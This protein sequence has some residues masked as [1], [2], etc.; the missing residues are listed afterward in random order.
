M[1]FRQLVPFVRSA[2]VSSKVPQRNP[3]Y[4]CPYAEVPRSTVNKLQVALKS[5]CVP[6]KA[7][8]ETHASTKGSSPKQISHIALRQLPARPELTAEFQKDRQQIKGGL[9]EGHCLG[10]PKGTRLF[11]SY[12]SLF[13][14]WNQSSTDDRI[15]A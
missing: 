6:V 7:T 10:M 12:S 2:T 14:Q 15:W 11:S 9:K 13:G 1:I 3:T 4:L 5:C 8:G